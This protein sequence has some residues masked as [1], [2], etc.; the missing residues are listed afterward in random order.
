MLDIFSVFYI[1]YTWNV[2]Y[3]VYTHCFANIYIY[4]NNKNNNVDYKYTKYKSY[5][6]YSICLKD[7]IDY[8]TIIN[9]FYVIDMK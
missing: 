9:T 4:N 3:L 2:L 6:M 5:H 1:V 7:Y 8:Q